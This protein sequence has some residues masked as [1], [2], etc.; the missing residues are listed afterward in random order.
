MLDSLRGGSA[1]AN[2][3][4]G[5]TS[6]SQKGGSTGSG[7]GGTLA[8]AGGAAAGGMAGKASGGTAGK[9]GTGGTTNGGSGGSGAG[10][11]GSDGC[12]QQLLK[13]PGFEQGNSNWTLQSDYPGVSAI[14]RADDPGLKLEGVAPREGNY[15]A[16]LG[17]IPDNQFES[18]YVAITQ[19]IHIPAAASSLTLTGYVRIKTEEPDINQTFDRGFIQLEY[20][21]DR[22]DLLWLPAHWTIDQANTDWVRFEAV[23]MDTSKVIDQDVMLRA[24][25]ETDPNLKSSFWLDSL[26]L[27]AKCG[28]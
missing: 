2:S 21:D 10:T 4:Q 28:R 18:Y 3:L 25:A 8:A 17:G 16:W 20:A 27:V 22:P 13:N 14:V 26:S 11:G 1:G 7:S 24:Q 6:N 9:A 5:G 15:L 23:L 19:V 12:S